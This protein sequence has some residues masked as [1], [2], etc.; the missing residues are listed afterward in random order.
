MVSQVTNAYKSYGATKLEKIIKNQIIYLGKKEETSCFVVV[1][2]GIKTS[3]AQLK[4][5]EGYGEI[6]HVL[7]MIDILTVK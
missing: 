5:L 2:A 4:T 3:I 1:W 6:H 7:A